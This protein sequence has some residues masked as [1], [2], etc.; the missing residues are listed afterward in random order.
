MGAITD[1]V[2]FDKKKSVRARMGRPLAWFLLFVLVA[3]TVLP[4]VWLMLS[5]FSTNNALFSGRFDFTWL[6]F[7]RV[8]GFASEEEILFASGRENTAELDFLRALRN[9]V[10]IASSIAIG[11]VF[12]SSMAAY[13]FARLKFKG[14]DKVFLFYLSGMMIPPIITLIPNVIFVRELGWGQSLLGIVAPFFLMTPFAV[15][16]MRQFFLSVNRSIEE[17]AMIDG[18]GAFRIFWSIN[19]PMVKPQMITLGVLTYVAA[20][21]EFLWPFVLSGRFEEVQPLTVALSVF[22]VQTP[23]NRPDWSGMLAATTIATLPILI[24]FAIFGKRIVDSI[25]FTGI[26]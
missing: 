23:G 10:L 11:Q 21:N 6:N 9:S 4:F 17:A 3:I 8:L 26:K 5:A 7:K 1:I 18:A 13:A 25:R 15:F 14:R 22:N 16:F 12:F 20:W 2:G 24:I 19:L